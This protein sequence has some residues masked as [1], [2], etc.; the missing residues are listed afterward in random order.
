MDLASTPELDDDEDEEDDEDDVLD[1]T[2]DPV[3][4]DASS[5]SQSAQGRSG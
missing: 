3:V 1:R 2:Q 4:G 5:Y